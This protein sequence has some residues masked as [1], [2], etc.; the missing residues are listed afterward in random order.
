MKGF[1]DIEAF[2][3]ICFLQE[4]PVY[5][6][7]LG[8]P[9][10]RPL[11]RP[12]GGPITA[13]RV[14]L[15]PGHLFS[16][17][18]FRPPAH[19]SHTAPNGH[20]GTVVSCYA[21]GDTWLSGSVHDGKA[22]HGGSFCRRLALALP[23]RAAPAGARSKH[24]SPWGSARRDPAWRSNRLRPGSDAGPWLAAQTARELSKLEAQEL[25]TGLRYTCTRAP[26][27]RKPG[28]LH[29]TERGRKNN[30]GPS[31]NSHSNA[32]LLSVPREKRALRFFT[33]GNV[34]RVPNPP[35]HSML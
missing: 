24:G 4:T 20:A 23:L 3:Q 19:A 28:L 7:P 16:H 11:A 31:C 10:T 27:A 18:S 14:P 25:Q 30:V 33:R 34:A 29:T 5:V 26:G 35:G 17:L 15:R 21:Q 32:D 13:P 6:R 1:P 2:F 8:R 9:H 22:C 12:L